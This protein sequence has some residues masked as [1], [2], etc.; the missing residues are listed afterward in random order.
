[1]LTII[2]KNACGNSFEMLTR[3]NIILLAAGEQ[4]A[5]DGPGAPR[6]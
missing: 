4:Q 1:M 5:N 6:L 2:K 3:L